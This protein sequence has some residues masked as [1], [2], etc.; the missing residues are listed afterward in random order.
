MLTDED[1]KRIGQMLDERL[2]RKVE[3]METRIVARITQQMEV[4]IG[5]SEERMKDFIADLF[6]AIRPAAR[7][8][9]AKVKSVKERVVA[10]EDRIAA[11][12]L[13]R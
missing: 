5:A 4:Q 13:K 2:D 12:E 8:G 3:G 9:K 11:L 6:L 7:P 10:M 1:V